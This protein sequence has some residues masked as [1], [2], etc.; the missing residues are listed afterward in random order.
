MTLQ[1]W[2]RIS[3]TNPRSTFTSPISLLDIETEAEGEE[4][5]LTKSRGYVVVATK[6]NTPAPQ[7]LVQ[8]ITKH[9][10]RRRRGLTQ[11]KKKV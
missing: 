1:S 9:K 2:G 4:L 3:N 8:P 5:M 11:K 7:R 10:R 6:M